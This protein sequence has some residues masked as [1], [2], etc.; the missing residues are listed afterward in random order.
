MN[1]LC[2]L[3]WHGGLKPCSCTVLSVPSAAPTTA[4]LPAALVPEFPLAAK[5]PGIS[6][7]G[8][9]TWFGS[10]EVEEQRFMACHRGQTA[11]SSLRL[12]IPDL[13]G[14]SPF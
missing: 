10:W 12:P 1:V 2:S 5:E 9:H 7:K 14:E 8:Q 6:S 3:G 11:N 13:G 4:A